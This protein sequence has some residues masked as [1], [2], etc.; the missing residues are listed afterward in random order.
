VGTNTVLARVARG[1]ETLADTAEITRLGR[2][3]DAGRKLDPEAIARTLAALERAA[4]LAR[5]FGAEIV[6][7]GTSALRDA[8]NAAEFLEPAKEILGVDVDVISGTREAE[9]TFRGALFGI[10]LHGSSRVTTVDIGGGSTEIARGEGGRMVASRSL[11]VGSVRLHERHVKSDPATKSE[12]AAVIEDVE[13]ALDGCTIQLEAPLVAIAG[14]A[15]TVA[16]IARGI[17]PYDPNRVHG[18]QIT[19]GEI[20]SVRE[21][22]EPLTLEE[23]LKIP[24]LEAGRADVILAGTL[25]LQRIVAAAG[26]GEIRISDGGVRVGLLLEKLG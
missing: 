2:G 23:R 3:V 14:T 26:V 12:I 8:S 20:A 24:G 13:R 7:V 15:T 16:A 22:L 19:A 21:R 4:V 18:A 17:D 25:L 10:D 1:G 6:A 9:L 5:S 11:D